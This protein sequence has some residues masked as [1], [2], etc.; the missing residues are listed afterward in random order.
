[1]G[2]ILL[3]FPSGYSQLTSFTAD[4]TVVVSYPFS[5]GKDSLFVFYSSGNATKTGTLSAKPEEAGM[6]N[7][8]WSRYNPG[9]GSFDAP[10]SIQMNIPQS[11]VSELVAGGYKVRIWNGAGTDTTCLGW[12]MTDNLRTNILKKNE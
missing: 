6:Y 9:N 10:F 3:T 11:T 1:V 5:S 2:L 12:V 8:S 4:L 7:F